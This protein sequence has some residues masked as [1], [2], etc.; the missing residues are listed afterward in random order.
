MWK[1]QQANIAVDMFSH[2]LVME[3]NELNRHFFRFIAE[4]G[5]AISQSQKEKQ[6]ILGEKRKLF[7]LMRKINGIECEFRFPPGPQYPCCFNASLIQ[8]INKDIENIRDALVEL[9]D[10]PEAQ[11]LADVRIPTPSLGYVPWSWLEFAWK[12]HFLPVQQIFRILKAEVLP[13]A[14]VV[15]VSDKWVDLTYPINHLVQQL[16][17]SPNALVWCRESKVPAL[18]AQGAAEV[19]HELDSTGQPHRLRIKTSPE[20]LTLIKRI[21]PQS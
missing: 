15:E 5:T 6:R 11:A 8:T 21:P 19:V 13:P 4:S 10:L 3:L 12:E 16:G 14:R 18:V 17:L 20:S 9:L 7:N 2:A 1:L